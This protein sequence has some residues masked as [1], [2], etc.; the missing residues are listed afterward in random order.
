MP[1]AARIGDISVGVC[2]CH[3]TCIGWTG[4]IISGAGT[5][6]TENSG[7]ARIGDIAVSCHSQI[8]VTGSGTHITENSGSA[9]N[10]DITVGCTNGVIV[11]NA[12][13][14]EIGG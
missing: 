6:S 10:G 11:T 5:R 12:G 7:Q 1:L 13:T 2:C 3:P 4:V 8:I 14:M 9:R